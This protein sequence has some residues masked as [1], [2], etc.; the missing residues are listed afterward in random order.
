ML[1]YMAKA[2]VAIAKNFKKPITPIFTF[3]GLIF[4]RVIVGI[5]MTLDSLLFS[6]IKEQKIVKP[7]VIV[8]NPRSGTTFLQRFLVNNKVGVGMK[9]WKMLFPALTI[10]KMVKP[11]L[12]SMEK[13]SPARFHGHAAHETNLTAIETD[14]PSLLFR[15]FDGFFVYGF[16]LA[17]AEE[18]L[19]NDFDPKFR[20]TSKR[21]FNWLKEVWKRN[22]IGEEH[23]QVVAK[24]FSLGIRLPEFLEH[25][26]DAKILYTLRDPMDTVPSG[27]SLVTGVLDG[28]YGFWTLPEEKRSFYIERLYNAFLELSLRFHDDF[29][30]GRINTSKVKVV[31]FDRMMNDFEALMDEIFEFI[32]IEPTAELIESVGITADK[33]R[34]FKSNHKYDLA[35]FGL[36]E[37]RIRKDYAKIYETF[38]S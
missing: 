23:H 13:V 30:S 5:G 14:D 31:R 10:Q 15:Y 11:F 3:L 6:R 37:D 2:Y 36:S 16:F 26:P 28:R 21:D 4:L 32:E 35:K 12:P 25:F 33:Q 29:V 7:I 18:D 9:L 8:G 24:L 19:K 20:D 17:W 22:L 27:L 38:F 1:S 34:N